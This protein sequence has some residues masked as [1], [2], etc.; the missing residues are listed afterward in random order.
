[1][2]LTAP[3]CAR[4]RAAVLLQGKGIYL[5]TDQQILNDWAHALAFRFVS[6][7]PERATPEALAMAQRWAAA[8]ALVTVPE[9]TQ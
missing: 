3:A 2:R 5:M 6:E 9:L 1:M 8:A 7:K 4:P